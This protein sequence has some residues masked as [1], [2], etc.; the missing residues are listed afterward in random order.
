[1]RRGGLPGGDPG[2]RAS[3]AVFLEGASRGR[4]NSTS[5]PSPQ[6]FTLFP[7]RGSTTVFIPGS[8]HTG[9]ATKPPDPHR[10]A[11]SCRPQAA[12]SS[13]MAAVMATR[14]LTFDHDEWAA[15]RAA[16]PLTLSEADLAT[17]RGIN[18]RISLDEVASIYLPLSRLLNLRVAAT[19]NLAKVTDTFLG[20]P[21]GRVP[22]VIG[23]AGSVAVG[24]STTARILQALLAR[25][26]DHPTVDL[27]TTD[28]FLYPNAVLEERGLMERKGFPESYDLRRLVQFMSAVKSGEPEVSAPLYSHL[29]YDVLPGE[30]LIVRQPDILILEGLNVLQ[31]GSPAGLHVSDFFDFSM[32]V[33]AVE[34]DVEQWYVDRFLALR[35]TAFKDPASFFRHFAALSEDES[36][37]IAHSIWASINGLNLRENILPTR[38]RAT[39]ILEKAADHS[40]QQVRLWRL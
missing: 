37:K 35:E 36:V 3:R 9:A 26:P 22:Y 7:S 11:G 32:Y 18:E 17:L 31:G 5:S 4:S 30:Q 24:K 25:W 21:A 2:V 28:G 13:R 15:L 20:Q 39:L 33:D 8:E 29:V 1:M 27:V 10:S 23:I 40:V 34:A 12:R 16:T 38:E 6:S 19:Q 14:Y